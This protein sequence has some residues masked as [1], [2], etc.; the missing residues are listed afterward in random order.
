MI[1]LRDGLLEEG[2][3]D[4]IITDPVYEIKLDVELLFSRVKGNLIV[5]CAPENRPAKKPDEILFWMKP[6]STKNFARKCGRFVEEICIYSKPNRAF[7]PIHWSC[8]TGVFTDNLQVKNFHPWQKPL[9]LMQKLIRIYSNP[10]DLIFDPFA[11]SGTTLKAALSLGRK[12]LGCEL[13]Y[14]AV[15]L[16]NKRLLD[17]SFE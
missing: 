5:F 17:E 6:L 11:G 10:G 3:F 14:Q 12:A 7:N 4:H 8:M 13:S 2:P 15:E 16:A 1:K 9:S